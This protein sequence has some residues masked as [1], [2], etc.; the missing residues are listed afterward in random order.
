MTSIFAPDRVCISKMTPPFDPMMAPTRSGGISITSLVPS[1][2]LRH[3]TE[4]GT[5]AAAP[6]LLLLLLLLL[7]PLLG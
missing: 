5:A 2:D 3:T 4:N 1:A 6:L 7:L